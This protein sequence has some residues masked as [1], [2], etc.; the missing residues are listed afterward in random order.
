MNDAISLALADGVS[1]SIA[2]GD[3]G[4]K[5]LVSGLAEVMQL[6]QSE[7]AT[8]RLLAFTD[9]INGYKVYSKPNEVT[10]TLASSMPG[11]DIEKQLPFRTQLM[12]LAQPMW[13]EAQARGGLLIHGA[14]AEKDGGGVIMTGASGAGKST[15]CRRLPPPW[16]TLSDDLTLVVRDP[17]GRYWAHPWPTWSQFLISDHG[18]RWE[19][20]K[21]VPLKSI[22]CLDRGDDDELRAVDAGAAAC[23]LVKSAE[24]AAWQL[25]LRME[26]E[27]LS[28][29]MSVQRFN[30]VCILARSVPA[31]ILRLSRD[32]PFWEGLEHARSSGRKSGRAL[33][34]RAGK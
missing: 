29:E 28:R 26:D 16:Q 12:L 11:E 8:H 23:L 19:V 32:G 9:R 25:I 14:L 5:L 3:P 15:A 10:L 34:D 6:G 20:E 24:Q 13:L 7:G 31:Y 33:Q 22:V 4:A 1:W 17:G 18:G 21:A 30:N 27:R 2:A